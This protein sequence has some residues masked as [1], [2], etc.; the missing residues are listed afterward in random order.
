MHPLSI[1]G[2]TTPSLTKNR[3]CSA[4]EA[5]WIH[6]CLRLAELIDNLQCAAANG[7]RV[8]REE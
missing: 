4:K 2:K 6:E 7:K 1:W 5:W 3:V 8:K